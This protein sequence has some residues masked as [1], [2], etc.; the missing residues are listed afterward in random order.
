MKVAGYAWSI[1]DLFGLLVL[2]V[3][4]RRPSSFQSDWGAVGERRGPETEFASQIGLLLYAT[5]VLTYRAAMDAPLLFP[6]DGSTKATNKY[7]VAPVPETLMK[8]R[9]SAGVASSRS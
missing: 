3:E 1:E 4:A 6:T 5:A 2:E 8:T 7:R 9:T